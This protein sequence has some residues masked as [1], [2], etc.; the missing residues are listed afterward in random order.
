M[1]ETERSTAPQSPY[2]RG[3]VA[4]GL[5]VLAVGLGIVFGVPVLGTGWLPTTPI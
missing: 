5:L 2:S 3:Q 4:V 1:T